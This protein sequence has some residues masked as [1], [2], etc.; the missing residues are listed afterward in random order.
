[1]T[2]SPVAPDAA[3]PRTT[4][5]WALGTFFWIGKLRPGSG[6]WASLVTALAWYG[7]ARYLTWSMQCVT[8]LAVACIVT[9]IGIP[10]ATVVEEESGVIDPGFVVIDEVAGQ[11]I[12][13]IAVPVKWPYMLASF[14]L[15]RAF[16]ILKPPP[17]RRLEKFPQ[18]AGI[19]LDDVGAGF[20]ALLCVQLLAH[21]K[22]L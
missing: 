17:L 6:T 20:Y 19:M 11:M 13:L 14:I 21:F 8:A 9:I 10:A 15:F 2:T 22:V 18:G 3:E 1:M 12:A 5:A 16:D 7:F 4:W